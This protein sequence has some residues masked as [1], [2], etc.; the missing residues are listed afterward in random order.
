MQS[1]HDAIFYTIKSKPG[2]NGVELVL[3]VSAIM[4]NRLILD[5]Y[6]QAIDSLI[7]NEDIKEEEYTNPGME[8]RVKS[9]YFLVKDIGS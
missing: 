3:E 4:E 7:Q 9:R 8:W 5:E 1:L 6:Y 2:I